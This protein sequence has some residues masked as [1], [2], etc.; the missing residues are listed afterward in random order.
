MGE[1][2]Y[3]TVGGF[4]LGTAAPPALYVIDRQT[5]GYKEE[6]QCVDIQWFFFE[7]NAQR[8]THTEHKHADL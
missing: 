3:D 2:E 5:K 8:H 4:K 1:C 6:L 7:P